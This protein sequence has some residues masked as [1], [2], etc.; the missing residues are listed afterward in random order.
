MGE[1]PRAPAEFA[2]IIA[3]DDP[4]LLIGG[5][6]VNIWAELYV[7]AAPELA[8]FEPFMSRDA[9]IFGTRA[10][11]AAL[12]ARAGWDCHA[13]KP[14][15]VTAAILVKSA[16]DGSSLVVEVLD[17]VNGLSGADLALH[18]TVAARSGER[19]RVLSPLVL[20]KAKLY[21][22]ISLV[23]QDRPQD[24]RHVRMLLAI[25]P[26]YLGEMVADVRAGKVPERDL[27]GAIR[28]LGEL[29]RLPWVGN[30]VRSH[31]LDLRAMFPTWL[32][33]ACSDG[34]RT[35]IAEIAPPE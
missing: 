9:D 29:I 11:A 28:Y 24:L 25:V 6:A 12:A 10:L 13:A 21:N 4:P 2:A 8:E 17:E 22:L 19:Y 31:G 23:G 26:H 18:A 27:L 5:Q 16:S 20:L 15:T 1:Q 32:R 14:D 33:E 30:A 35:A 3:G 7:E 34:A